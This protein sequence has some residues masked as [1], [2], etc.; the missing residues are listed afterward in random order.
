MKRKNGTIVR[1]AAAVGCAVLSAAPAWAQTPGSE[2]FA[3]PLALLMRWL[4]ILA[5]V[6]AIG[7]AFYLRFLVLPV[8][9]RQLG[10]EDFAKLRQALGERWRFFVHG[11]VALLLISGL[12][13]YL[14][15]TRVQHAGQPLYHMLFGIKF[16]LALIVFFVAEALVSSRGWSK[17]LRAQARLWLGLLLGVALLVILIAGVMKMMGTAAPVG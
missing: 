8:A 5:A 15:V 17:G 11:A 4:H 2:V 9:A 14:A 7:G 6:V 13:N 3:D 10:A 16:L 1:G 12:Y